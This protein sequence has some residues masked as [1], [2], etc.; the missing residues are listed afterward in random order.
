MPGLTQERR[1]PVLDRDE[2]ASV[3]L[4]GGHPA[5]PPGTVAPVVAGACQGKP[6]RIAAPRSPECE[7]SLRVDEVVAGPERL[8]LQPDQRH[9]DATDRL[10]VRPHD[11][12]FDPPLK[13]W[14]DFG[15]VRFEGGVELVQGHAKRLL[16][17]RTFRLY[18]WS[19]APPAA[20]SAS[21]RSA[22]AP[23]PLPERT[24]PARHLDRG[25]CPQSS[26]R[27]A[28]RPSGDTPRRQRGT[29]P[30][31]SR[32]PT[33]RRPGG[34]HDE[35]TRG[36]PPDLPVSRA[37]RRRGSRPGSRTF[38][39]GLP[40]G[41]YSLSVRAD[42]CPLDWTGEGIAIT[43]VSE[44]VATVVIDKA[45]VQGVIINLTA[46]PSELCSRIRGVVR[47]PDGEAIGGLVVGASR[48]RQRPTRTRR[49]GR[50]LRACS[51][52]ASGTGC[53][54]C[55][56]TQT[57]PASV[58]SA[59]TRTR[60]V[61][62]GGYCLRGRQRHHRPPRRRRRRPAGRSAVD[63]VRC[64]GPRA[65]LWT[66]CAIEGESSSQEPVPESADPPAVSQPSVPKVRNR[67]LR[68]D[69]APLP[70]IR[71]GAISVSTSTRTLTDS[72]GAFSLPSALG[73]EF[74]LSVF[75]TSSDVCFAQI[76]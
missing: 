51:I 10:A 6:Q 11:R 30:A 24:R 3:P 26:T 38:A 41:S 69:G 17:T 20:P 71:V 76:G 15:A 27:T 1:R 67:V 25:P 50:R 21:E 32:T 7:R 53:I 40:S 29:R 9:E 62:A 56:F 44:Q 12:A 34:S 16:E 48:L 36:S 14:R 37:S 33:Q 59:A 43:P 75:P 68:P 28:A 65:L 49:T 8:A 52:F 42:Q 22:A 60:P 70:G 47:S 61:P 19:L 5:Q 35:R 39:R 54:A 4:A 66:A 23:T 73:K 55:T 63:R 58:R 2:S 45:V 72:D 46:T 31:S 13:R 74:T 18:L 64:C 57:S